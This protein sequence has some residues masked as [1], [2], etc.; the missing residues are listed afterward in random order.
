MMNDELINIA[1]ILR[2]Y[3]KTRATASSGGS[4]RLLGGIFLILFLI[5]CGKENPVPAYLH[6]PAFSLT[7]RVGEGTSAHKIS[8]AWVFVDGQANG[9]YQLPVTIPVVE[10][11]QHDISIFP[12]VRNNGTRSNPVVYPMCT[13][14]KI[15]LDLKAGKVDTVRPTTAYLPDLQFKIV[16]DFE[17]GNIFKVD[18]DNNT[19]NQF[20]IANNGFEGKCGQ[21][22]LGKSNISM[23]KASTTKVQLSDNAANIYLE[24]HY[25]TEAPL[26][27][28]IVGSNLSNTAGTA[29]YKIILYPNKEWNKTYINL[30]NEVKEL[31]MTDFQIL[32][33]SLLPDSL[34]TATILIDNIKLIQK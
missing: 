2:G 17:R 26:T 7:A 1:K 10:L 32:F 21:F 11:G 20:T 33:N 25:K 31:K 30:T 14:Y 6:I 34:S 13:S 15:K 19:T 27:V 22:I 28:G 23:E 12:G 16:E 8:D 9:I 18:R 3:L 5:S 4:G 24:M 29:N